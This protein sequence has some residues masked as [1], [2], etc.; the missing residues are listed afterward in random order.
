KLDAL[1]RDF[2]EFQGETVPQV[3]RVSEK[4]ECL[5][6]VN[7]ALLTLVQKHHNRLVYEE[8]IR[9][10]TVLERELEEISPSERYYRMAFLVWIGLVDEVPMDRSVIY[11]LTVQ[12]RDFLAA[13]HLG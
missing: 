8:L 3:P 9:R 6:P 4:G 5:D 12:G 7:L 10:G 13:N 11:K 1:R 2:E